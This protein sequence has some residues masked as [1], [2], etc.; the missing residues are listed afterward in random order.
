MYVICKLWK[1]RACSHGSGG[2]RRS[3]VPHLPVEEKYVFTCNPG[4]AGWGPKCNYLVAKHANKQRTL[5]C[6]DEAAFCYTVVV[7]GKP[8]VWL[9]WLAWLSDFTPACK[10]SPVLS[11]SV[12]WRFLRWN[13]WNN[14]PCSSD[15]ITLIRRVPPLCSFQ[16]EKIHPT[17]AGY[18]DRL[19]G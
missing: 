2:P 9:S 16:M 6:S 11:I 8:L 17:E 18:P 5:F 13:R 7:P 10:L 19:T 4:D 14:S 3:E 15:L 12:F 1:L